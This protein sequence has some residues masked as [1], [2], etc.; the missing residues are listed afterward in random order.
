MKAKLENLNNTYAEFGGT[1]ETKVNCNRYEGDNEQADVTYVL[2]NGKVFMFKEDPSDGYR[3]YMADEGQVARP[4]AARFSLEHAPQ[5][6]FVQ[7]GRLKTHKEYSSGDF[8]G[9][10]LFKGNPAMVAEFGTDNSDDYYPS[11]VSFVNVEAI[12]EV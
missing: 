1:Y 8:D 11:A 2:L 6:V 9:L 4:K 12:N 7:Y 3:S 10:R 5:K